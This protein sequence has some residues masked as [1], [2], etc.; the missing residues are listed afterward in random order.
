MKCCLHGAVFYFRKVLA[1]QF[2]NRDKTSI[3]RSR[4]VVIRQVFLLGISVPD[5]P[6]NEM[7]LRRAFIPP[8]YA[9][10]EKTDFEKKARCSPFDQVVIDF[11][12][13]INE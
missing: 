2:I 5:T 3:T 10:Y 1:L 13:L 11:C 9:S 7:I 6:G 4:Q 8:E 12:E